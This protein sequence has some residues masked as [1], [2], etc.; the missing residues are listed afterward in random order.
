MIR[1]SPLMALAAF[2]LSAY[3]ASAQ[4]YAQTTVNQWIQYGEN[5][6]ILARAIVAPTPAAAGDGN[7]PGA[8]GGRR[9]RH[10]ERAIH[11]LRGLPDHRMRGG[12]PGGPQRC[13]D[14]RRVAEATG[15]QP[16][17][18]SSSSVIP[19]AGLR[20]LPFRR[21]NDPVQFPLATI[22]NFVASFSPD[23]IVH[24]GD[25]YYRENACPTA[26]AG[27]GTTT[28]CGGSPYGDN[29]ASWNADWFTPARAMM[30]AAPLALTRGNH[31]SCARGNMGWFTLLDPEAYTAAAISCSAGSVYDFTPPY[32]INAGQVSLLMFDSSYANDSAVTPHRRQQLPGGAERHPAATQA[33]HH[34]R[35]AQA[36]I[37]PDQRRG[38][39]VRRHHGFGR[40][41]GRAGV[42]WQRRAG[43][44]QDAAVWPHSQLPGGEGEQSVLCAA[45]GDR[46]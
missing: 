11:A 3:P 34:F 9:A 4:I 23:L 16:R 32:I 25:Y 40:R 44:N 39:R 1:L 24:V 10:H 20:A 26:S 2:G 42:V 27:N 6:A 43:A 37:R 14:Q 13:R 15:G 45:T 12:G 21:C 17:A 22:S 28:G 18:G 29:W 19:A 36:R 7:L 41:R 38:Q 30:A 8:L 5:G 35:D 31:E 33:E 46:Q